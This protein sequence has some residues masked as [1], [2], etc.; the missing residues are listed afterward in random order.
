MSR[1][2]FTK[3]LAPATPP[4]GKIVIYAKSDGRL[5]WKD[6]FGVEVPF[7][8]TGAGT[9]DLMSD[10][11]V[12]LASNWPAGSFKIS[13]NQLEST[14][15]SGTAPF[16]VASNTVV[17]NLNADLLDGQEGA[18]YASVAYV[19]AAVT[20][21]YDHKGAYDA[22]TNTPDLDTSPSGIEKGDAYT[23][24]VAGTFYAVSLEAGDVLIADQDDPTASNEWTI[25]NR[26]IDS[27]AFATAAQGALADT[28]LQDLTDDATPQ[29]SAPL[30]AQGNTLN[31]LGVMFLTGQ[32]AAVADVAGKGQIW[33]KNT[34]PPELWYTDDSGQDIRIGPKIES[35]I[36]ALGDEDTG[37]GTGT[38]MVTIRAP[39]GFKVTEV[40]ANV[41]N[42]TGT[43]TLQ[44][45][46]K[47]TGVSILSTNITIDATETTST[48][49]ATPP[50]ISDA[51]IA[52]DAE[53][54]L[55][56]ID[57]GD[58]S[59]AGLKVTLKGFVL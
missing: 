23:C 40:R 12:P 6:E 2:I 16:I 51:I 48:T 4:A 36:I 39:Y 46:V 8:T 20:G 47:E 50:V 35:F 22:S 30:D 57:A 11:S 37:V 31:N 15:A 28:A 27:S 9:G 14:V 13:S 17:T 1:A 5:Y 54:S 42:A 32:A 59:A 41:N 55:D 25:V 58:G 24:S 21:L 19:D 56:V 34:V 10:G 45:D 43:G 3:A 49:A 44:V 38:D 52:D 18:Y 33:V 26:N 29:L 7:K 53:I